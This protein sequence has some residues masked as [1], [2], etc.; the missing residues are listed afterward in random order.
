[1]QRSGQSAN[2][3]LL[4]TLAVLLVLLSHCI[5]AAGNLSWSGIGQSGVLLFFVHTALVLM[6]SLERL[7]AKREFIVTFYLHRFFRIYPLALCCMALCLAFRIP[8]SPREEFQWWGW[9][10]VALNIMFVQNLTIRVQSISGPLWSLCYEIQMYLVLPFVFLVAIRKRG[11]WLVSAL[12]IGSVRF[13]DRLEGYLNVL[14]GANWADMLRNIR[15]GAI[16]AT[17]R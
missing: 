2:L 11:L 1:M 3:D 6:F 8:V 15:T 14:Y 16:Y 13:T 12:W 4:R 17:S 7:Q 9:R 10:W 5:Y